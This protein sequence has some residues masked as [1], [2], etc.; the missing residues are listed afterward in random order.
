MATEASSGL[1]EEVGEEVAATADATPKAAVDEDGEV[2]T[3]ADSGEAT[4]ADATT[5]AAADE[6]SDTSTTAEGDITDLANEAGAAALAEATGGSGAAAATASSNTWDRLNASGKQSSL[7]KGDDGK[8]YAVKGSKIQVDVGASS[9]NPKVLKLNKKGTIKV[10]KSGTATLTSDLYG[11]VEATVIDPKLKSKKAETQVGGV[12]ELSL[13]N[14]PDGVPVAWYSCNQDVVQVVSGN[15]YGVGVGKAKVIAYAGGKAFKATVKVTDK[16][17]ST[18]IINA[19]VSKAVKIKGLKKASKLTYDILSEGITITKGKVMASKASKTPVS[20]NVSDGHKLLVYANET[21]L[22]ENGL[23]LKVGEK[24]FILDD[25][26][27]KFPEFKSKN[28]TIATISEYGVVIGQAPGKTVI[29]AK[30]G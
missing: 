15:C 27:H 23:S 2:S 28:N 30:I 9:S 20:V 19:D 21:S 24:A 5:K 3:A 16:A 12:T 25:N 7:F 4:T 26:M 18:L 13:E 10:G 14:V 22:K 6:F 8:Y 1:V 11:T 29:T 17:D